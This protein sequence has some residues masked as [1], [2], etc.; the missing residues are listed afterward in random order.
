MEEYKVGDVFEYRPVTQ[1]GVHFSVEVVSKD[2]RWI[3]VRSVRGGYLMCIDYTT[4]HNEYP[5]PIALEVGA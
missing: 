3:T 5:K 4:L 1:L 2:T